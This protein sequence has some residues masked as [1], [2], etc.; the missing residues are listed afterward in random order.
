MVALIER[1]GP[2]QKPAGR[3]IAA[4]VNRLTDLEIIESLY[5]ASQT[6]VV[7]DLIADL[8]GAAGRAGFVSDN[9]CSIV[10]RFLEHSRIFYFANGEKRRSYRVSRLDDQKSQSPRQLSH[11]YSTNS[12]TFLKDR[13][14]LRISRQCSGPDPDRGRSVR[15]SPGR[16]RRR[17]L[18]QSSIL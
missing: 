5:R 18:Q 14:W 4:K 16:T 8:Y 7:I 12:W 3:A 6:G 9:Q 11:R 13:Y 17:A 15:G 2:R 1:D 10:G